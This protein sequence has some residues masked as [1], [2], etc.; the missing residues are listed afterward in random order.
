MED[1]SNYRQVYQ[2]DSLLESHAN[3]DPMMQF[4]KWF[5]EAEQSKIQNEVN[6]MH[7]STIGLDGF[8]KTRVVLLKSYDEQGFV[9][10]TNYESEKSKAIL[11]NSHVCLSFFWPG[12][13]RQVIIKG[14]AEKV[15]ELQSDNYFDSRPL[16][17]RLGAI[18]SEQSKVIANYQVL[19]Q[20]LKQLQ[21]LPEDSIKRPSNWGGF[22]VR[23][24][25]MEFWQGRPNRLHDR[26]LYTIDQPNWQWIIERLAP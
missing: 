24:V 14:L 2:K 19:E 21:A 16:G 23:P 20:R 17:S 6:A 7:L 4:R 12:M 22:L 5:V 13:E 26:L 1:L 9:F 25:T 3:K 18:A 11:D 8:P 15:S 10:Y